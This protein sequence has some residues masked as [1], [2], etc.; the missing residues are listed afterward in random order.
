MS[1]QVTHTHRQLGGRFALVAEHAGTGALE[2]QGVAIYLDIDKDITSATTTDDWRQ[3]WRPIAKDDCPVCLGTGTD[4]IKG[5]KRRPCGGCFGL[6]KVKG[7]GETPGDMWE[8]ATVATGIIQRQLQ[9]LGQLHEMVAQPELQSAIQVL[10]QRQHE[11]ELNAIARSEQQW[12]N[13]QGRAAGGR[14]HTG[15]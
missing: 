3:Q 4:Q 1:Q 12:R 10:Q 7:D 13:G 9:E 11:A 5:N 14:R 15:D 8:L 2:G 6:G